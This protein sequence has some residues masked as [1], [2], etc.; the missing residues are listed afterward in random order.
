MPGVPGN[1]AAAPPVAQPIF[2]KTDLYTAEIDAAG[3]VIAR[4]SL[5]KHRA[6]D[7]TELPYD[8]LQKT[9]E[10]TFVAQSGL[11]GAGLPNHR[12]VYEVLPGPRELAAGADSLELRLQATAPNGDKVVQV[13]TFHRGSYVIDVAY[14]ITN[15][16]SAPIAPYAYYQFTRDTKTPTVH[17]SMAPSSFTGPVIYDEADKY[18]KID[19]KEHRQARRGS[20]AQAA[21]HQERRQRL[22][23]HGRALLRHR[24]AAARRAEDA[25]RVLH[26]QARQ[27]PVR[28]RRDRAGRHASPRARP[29]R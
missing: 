10:R 3:G 18:K 22:G 14:D 6:T 2:I 25:A 1:E 28:R 17:T 23:R 29:A 21:V 8:V 7:H 24:V 11:L 20:V 9:A 13:M 27:R 12:T 19:F 16:G 4:V 26:A 5:T 15:A